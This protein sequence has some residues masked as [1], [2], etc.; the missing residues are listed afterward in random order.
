[1]DSNQTHPTEATIL[2]VDDVPENRNVL[3]E[4]LEP[5]GY[6]ILIAPSEEVVLQ[7][8]RRT[9]PDLILLDVIMPGID[10]F[11][12]CRQ[13]KQDGCTAEIPVIFIT[14]RD[15][16]EELVEGFRTGGVDYIPK[17]FQEAEVLARVQTHLKINRLIRELQREIAQ[18]K[19][20]TVE[21]N[22]LS[23]RLDMIRRHEAAQWGIDE[24][25]GE[26]KLIRQILEK[27]NR[28]HNA[29]TTTVLI[30]GESGTGKELVARAIH[31]GS[32]RAKG[33]FVPVNCA[34]IPKDLAESLCFGHV[35]GA[36]TGAA[37]DQEGYLSLA[38]GG[39]LFLDEVGEM[40]LEL[41]AKLLRVLDDRYVVPIGATGGK[42][43]NVRILA[44]TNT[45]LAV[46]LN[47]GAFRQDLYY[48]LA[49]FQ[50]NIPPLRERM[51]DI[52]ILA[53]HFLDMFAAEM[54]IESPSINP[55]ALR[56][57][58]AHHFPG[59]VR[60]LKHIIEGALIECDGSEIFPRHLH[61][62]ESPVSTWTKLLPYFSTTYSLSF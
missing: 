33:L 29:N 51:E 11:E 55:Q 62:I 1:M 34:A 42:Y 37:A 41:Q 59:N 4:L 22:H 36:F 32:P 14:I 19:A 35:R 18:R 61:F 54:G 3:S 28:L 26:S 20:V 57:L 58:E 53:N 16:T 24:I 6:E 12:T 23:D 49:Q 43:V 56:A 44:A 50:V 45:D 21:R 27:I 31:F 40:P 5:Q 46:K 25:V 13:L 30:T 52:P 10:G 9:T 7:V 48:R 2:I 15:K 60:E 38:D 8:A 47:G 17:P 39:T